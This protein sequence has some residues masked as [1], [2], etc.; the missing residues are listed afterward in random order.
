[1][2]DSLYTCTATCNKCEKKHVRK[3]KLEQLFCK[4]GKYTPSIDFDI[5]NVYINCDCQLFTYMNLKKCFSK[6]EIQDY[7]KN[8]V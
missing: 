1:M 3:F 5:E 6:E 8:N 2:S 4:C 7:F